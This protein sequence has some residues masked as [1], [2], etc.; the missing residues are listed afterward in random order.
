MPRKGKRLTIGP[1][2]YRDSSG[3]EVAITV[4]GQRYSARMP[5]DSTL[6][7]LK[8]KRAALANQGHTE[9]PRAEH[10]TLRK[11]VPTYLRL[12]AHLASKDDLEDHLDA[13]CKELG[14]VQ[15]HRITER[16]VSAI[17]AKWTAAGT[18]PKT[19]N[20]RVGTLRN[21]YH[22]LDGP[23]AKTPCDEL[24]A[25]KIAK[26]IIQRVSDQMLLAVDAKLQERER[27]GILK[28][29][30]TR[31]R[32]RVFVSTGK[33]PCEIMRAL[34]SDVNLEARVWVPRDAKGGYCPGAYLND[35]QRAA[36]QLFIDADAWG[37]YNHGAF[38]RTIRAA[39]WP[40]TVR[41]YQAR[42]TTWITASEKGIDLEDIAIGAGHR[43]PRMTRRMYVPVLNSRLQR[44]GEALEGRFQG[45]PV[46]PDN[47]TA[48]KP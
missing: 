28:D 21:L 34:P 26:T 17:R 6:A 36:W 19:I 38:A 31:A 40:K 16:D 41:P 5:K 29:A 3:Y 2:L 9:T 11:A 1:G 33:R 42:H 12:V 24:P 22:R 35:D 39:G 30:K 45:W 4:G 20:N 23:K 10:G 43:D 44:L 7:E 32:F 47:G 37:P 18:S 48:I 14:D 8:A 25:L 15:R 46:V 13:W 27:D